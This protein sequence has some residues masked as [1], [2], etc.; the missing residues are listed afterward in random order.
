MPFGFL[1]Y[2]PA[3]AVLIVAGSSLHAMAQPGPLPAARTVPADTPSV[4]DGVFSAAQAESGREVFETV[5]VRCHT[6]DHFVPG[7]LHAITVR[8]PNVGEMYT[9][10]STRM[11]LDD[12]G[13]RTPEEYAAVVSYILQENRYPAGQ[14]ELPTDVEKLK[15]I[16]IVPVPA[17]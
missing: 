10:V 13:S 17:D 12:P 9:R 14:V 4:L 15:P 1:K 7:G 8:F 3:A 11:P 2:A 16:R 5:C 6:M